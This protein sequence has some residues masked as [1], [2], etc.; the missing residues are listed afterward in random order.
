MRRHTSITACFLI[1]SSACASTAAGRT[2]DK[3]VP[4]CVVFEPN[5]DGQDPAKE[6]KFLQ[7]YLSPAARKLRHSDDRRTTRDRFFVPSLFRWATAEVEAGRF[8]AAQFARLREVMFA[9]LFR[10]IPWLAEQF[11]KSLRA[12]ADNSGATRATWEQAA[13][14]AALTL[15]EELGGTETAEEVL[16]TTLTPRFA[17]AQPAELNAWASQIEALIPQ[18]IARRWDTAVPAWSEIMGRGAVSHPRNVHPG[19]L[20]LAFNTIGQRVYGLDAIF[21]NA[22]YTAQRNTEGPAKDFILT[23]EALITDGDHRVEAF[24]HE[25]AAGGNGIDTGHVPAMRSFALAFVESEQPLAVANPLKKISAETW[26]STIDPFFSTHMT[27]IYDTSRLGEPDTQDVGLG[28]EC[29]HAIRAW[30]GAQAAIHAG[31]LQS[32]LQDAHTFV[33]THINFMDSLRH[34]LLAL[35]AP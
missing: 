19:Q 7:R 6:A 26:R 27:I 20:E 31:G 5:L 21:T 33:S 13:Y 18:L 23:L 28:I 3:E 35:S 8:T 32:A 9:R 17:A 22:A 29:G 4:Q 30:N 1:V 24:T 25:L 12:M 16:R 15:N 34:E 11:A 10:T 2:R 14:T